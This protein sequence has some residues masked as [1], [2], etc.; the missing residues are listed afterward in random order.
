MCGASKQGSLMEGD[1]IH[2]MPLND[3]KYF[4]EPF[5]ED[6]FEPFEWT[7]ILAILAICTNKITQ[8]QFCNEEGHD[9]IP[10]CMVSNCLQEPV[11]TKLE[12]I[13]LENEETLVN[14]IH[15]N[16][17]STCDLDSSEDKTKLSMYDASSESE[18]RL[19][20][21]PKIKTELI[22]SQ[23]Q[24]KKHRVHKRKS[25]PITQFQ[26]KIEYLAKVN[27]E[28]CIKDKMTGVYTISAQKT[29]KI[30][31]QP[32]S[33]ITKTKNKTDKARNR[34]TQQDNW[35]TDWDNSQD[36]NSDKLSVPSHF[37]K[38]TVESQ[39]IV[40]RQPVREVPEEKI[41]YDLP[42]MSKTVNLAQPGEES[43]TV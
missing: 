16:K 10:L 9:I 42:K 19:S 37:K 1:C 40:L 11:E 8:T 17:I 27:A 30:N 5:L 28:D 34:E 23:N 6:K 32:Q 24:N 33:K 2:D 12:K 29:T 22:I 14:L 43:K 35:S 7:H 21:Q 38:Y 41:S 4:L 13:I 31:K 20:V 3:S 26:N 39:K 15:K 18:E 36:E 25:R